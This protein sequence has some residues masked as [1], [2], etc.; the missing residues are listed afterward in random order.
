ML[1]NEFDVAKDAIINPSDFVQRIEG[2]PKIA[3]GCFEYNI[4]EHIVEL[5]HGE[6][7]ATTKNANSEFPVY[8]IVYKGKEIALFVMD[9]GAAGA[10]AQLEEHYTLGI[11]TVILFG[12]CGVLNKNIQDCSIIIPNAAVRD[13]GLSYHYL[14]PS[15]EIEVNLK[16]IPEFTALLDEVK[17]SYRIGKTWTTDA[18]YRETKT[19]MERRK[20]QGCLCVEMECSALAAVAQFREKELFQFLYAADC[21][22]GEQWDKRSLGNELKLT[23]KDAFA[24]LALELA[25]RIDG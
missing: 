12:S 19:K 18:F 2:M 7:V 20:K 14:P 8:K 21:L 13:E 25:V 5:L 4:M 6:V 16:Y 24:Q 9:M 1:T 22:D 11:E 23:E 3:V 15:D 17:C 10:G